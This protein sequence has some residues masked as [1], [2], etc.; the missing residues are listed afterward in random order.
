MAKRSRNLNVSFRVS[1]Q[2]R[3]MIEKKMKLAGIRSLRAYMLKMAVDG[4]VVQLDLSEVR[5]MVSLLR[6]ATNNLNQIA[7]RTNEMGNLYAA[8]I[9]DLQEHYNRLWEQTGGIL[10]KLSAL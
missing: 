5:E 6:T 8:D 7:R 2:E 3:E 9:E 1:E 4:Y 10:K